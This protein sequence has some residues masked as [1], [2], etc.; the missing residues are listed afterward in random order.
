MI[1]K[2]PILLFV[3]LCAFILSAQSGKLTPVKNLSLDAKNKIPILILFS[4]HDCVYCEVAKEEALWPISNL[5][6]YKTKV[7]VREVLDDS[8]FN[9]FSNQ[10]VTGGEFGYRYGVSFY[11]TL[12]IVDQDGKELAPK[13]IGVIDKSI[14]WSQV[15]E[16]ID[17]ATQDE[18]N[19]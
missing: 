19:L 16:L 1:K 2:I 11:P 12:V 4:E 5:K 17:Y 15:D 18:E 7:M 9:D 8:V 6:D 3:I 14:Y 10:T 13:L